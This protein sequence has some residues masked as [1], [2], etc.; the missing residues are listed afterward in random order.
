MLTDAAKQVFVEAT[1]RRKERWIKNK[2]IGFMAD[3]SQIEVFSMIYDGWC[4]RFGKEDAVDFLLSAMCEAE[5]RLR[6]WDVA[7]RAS[8]KAAWLRRG[9]QRGTNGQFRAP[10]GTGLDKAQA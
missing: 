9:Q 2:K 4:Q 6:D 5:A 1:E 3:E 7:R 8:K 10:S